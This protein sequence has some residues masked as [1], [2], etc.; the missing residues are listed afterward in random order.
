MSEWLT[1][2]YDIEEI[3]KFI[4]PNFCQSPV[5]LVDDMTSATRECVGSRLPKNMA[6]MGT[7]HNLQRAS[8]LPN[9]E[10]RAIAQKSL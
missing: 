8:T 1:W 10:K 6:N 7:S 4:H 9:L 5:V 2:G 3:F